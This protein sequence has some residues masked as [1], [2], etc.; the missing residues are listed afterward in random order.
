VFEGDLECQ[1]SY[2]LLVLQSLTSA[3]PVL[4]V[5]SDL[6]F[7]SGLGDCPNSSAHP[8]PCSSGLSMMK[9]SLCVTFL[10]SESAE[11]DLLSLRVD[12]ETESCAWR[13]ARCTEAESAIESR[14]VESRPEGF[15]RRGGGGRTL[16]TSTE[17]SGVMLDPES[18]SDDSDGDDG[19]TRS[20]GTSCPSFL[21]SLSIFC[22]RRLLKDVILKEFRLVMLRKEVSSSSGMN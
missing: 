11:P 19:K 22:L 10:G 8:I 7:C 15:R 21:R 5:H 18:L 3:A 17:R 12:L 6:N 13:F 16:M 9:E 2:P 4:T 1:P 20:K 14:E